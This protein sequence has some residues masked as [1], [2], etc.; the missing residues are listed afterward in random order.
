ME[1]KNFKNF[2][3][4]SKASLIFM[5]FFIF[6]IKSWSSSSGWSWGIGYHN[7]PNSTIGVNFMHLWS[8]WAFE[9]GIGYINSSESN[10][11]NSSNTSSSSSSSSNNDVSVSAGGDLNFKYLF[12]YGTFRPYIQGGTFFGIGA[13][14]GDNSGATASANGG[15]GGLGFFIMSSSVDFYISYISAGNGSLQFGLNF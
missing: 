4:F 9:V 14:S 7:P 10:S 13:R 1:N 3:L 2:R 5:T 11:R 12:G 15:F 8:Q 6:S